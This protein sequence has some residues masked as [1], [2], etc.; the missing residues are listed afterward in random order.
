ML[1]V[2]QRIPS[3]RTEAAVSSWMMQ[4]VCSSTIDRLRREARLRRRERRAAAAR[5]E[6][7][8]PVAEALGREQSRWLEGQ[9]AQLSGTDRKLVEA[10]FGGDGTVA[11]AAAA[12][13]LGANAAHGRLRRCIER[14][15]RAARDWIGSRDQEP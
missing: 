10:R 12:L 15:R 9:L 1:K 14:L 13:G 6:V 8:D 7:P 4:T 2:S 3:L 11:A 5:D